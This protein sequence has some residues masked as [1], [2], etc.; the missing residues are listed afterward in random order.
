[1]M[2]MPGGW[3]VRLLHAWLHLLAVP[4]FVA[5]DLVMQFLFHVLM[6]G[7]IMEL[8]LL[9]MNCALYFFYHLL[10]TQLMVRSWRLTLPIV[11]IAFIAEQTASMLAYEI[12]LV[13]A[14]IIL[15]LLSNLVGRPI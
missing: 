14:P 1:M 9:I 13:Q 7:G 5:A 6:P 4:F 10:F 12:G 3:N 15:T 8:S 2:P 11:G